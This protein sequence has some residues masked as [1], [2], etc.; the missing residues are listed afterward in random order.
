MTISKEDI[1]EMKILRKQG[2]SGSKIGKRFGVTTSCVYYHT[3][4]GLREKSNLCSKKNE[5]KYK[6]TRKKYKE[7]PENKEANRIY[8]SRRRDTFDGRMKALYQ[9]MRKRNKEYVDA[10]DPKGVVHFMS[11]ET[12]NNLVQDY[13]EKYGFVDFYFIQFR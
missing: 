8:S 7:N 11:K 9:G 10:G 4:P 1:A 2:L 3:T 13:I 5:H 12:W 6:E